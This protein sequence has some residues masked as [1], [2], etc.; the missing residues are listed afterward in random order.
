MRMSI[1]T[2][3]HT[4]IKLNLRLHKN[5]HRRRNQVYGHF[6]RAVG[7][8]LRLQHQ[9]HPLNRLALL[10]LLQQASI[11]RHPIEL[12]SITIPILAKVGKI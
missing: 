10:P 8:Q 12:Q 1:H 4:D 3:R 9:L 7:I 11:T 2:I 5:R 6:L